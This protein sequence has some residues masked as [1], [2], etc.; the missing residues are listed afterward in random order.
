ETRQGIPFLMDV[1]ILGL[2]AGQNTTELTK[3]KLYLFIRPNILWSG[4]LEELKS[5]SGEKAKDAESLIQG[6]DL[7]ADVRDA[8]GPRD[9]GIRE[10]PLPFGEPKR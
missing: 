6:P 9:S 3:S 8:L 5:A 10:A 1:P 4:G 7:K 2:L